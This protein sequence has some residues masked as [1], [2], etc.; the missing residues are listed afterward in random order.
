[1]PKFPRKALVRTRVAVAVSLA[2]AGS[3]DL[4]AAPSGGQVT[5]GAASIQQ[6]GTQTLITQSTDRAAI[7]WQT[8]GIAATES[9]IFRQ[10]SSSSVA[11][12]RVI[13]GNPSEIFGRLQAN[14]H[15]FLINPSGILFG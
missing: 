4:F 7:N 10:P 9:V 8:F 5:A 13:G 1:G 11:L 2:L 14:G 15:V 12:N 3:N 6:S